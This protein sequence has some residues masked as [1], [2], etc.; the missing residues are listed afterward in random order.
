MRNA[1]R[2]IAASIT[3][4][5]AQ[6]H[7]KLQIIVID[8]GSEDRS[9]EIAPRFDDPRLTVVS[10]PKGG[11]A[12][13]LNAGYAHVPDAV[14]LIARQ[15][16]DDLSERGRLEAQI[17]L[18]RSDSR[19]ALVGAAHREIDLD[20]QTLRVTKVLTEPDAIRQRLRHG[21]PFAGASLL[22][23]RW[24]FDALGGYDTAF[25]GR[26]GEDYDFL[27][28]AAELADFSAV[29]EPLYVYRTNNPDSMCGAIGYDYRDAKAFVQ[30]R[31]RLRGSSIFAEAPR[32]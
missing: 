8:N 1:E 15:D 13:T 23:E 19:L 7:S 3:S 6:T 24:L 20:D 26:I 16:A 27:V 22:M 28:R 17:R 10:H 18:L 12:S 4:L 29:T 14:Q 2:W 11:L 5:L 9:L 25:D 32:A 21:N 30:K 31:A